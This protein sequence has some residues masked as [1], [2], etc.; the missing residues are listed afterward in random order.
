MIE[1]I[2]R[3]KSI[4]YPTK[5]FGDERYIRRQNYLANTV[6][7]EKWE[8]WSSAT[9]QI[10][11]QDIRDIQN[12]IASKRGEDLFECMPNTFFVK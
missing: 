5:S 7:K 12:N 11:R 9:R 8:C 2:D 3:E 4:G 1:V 6:K 10:I